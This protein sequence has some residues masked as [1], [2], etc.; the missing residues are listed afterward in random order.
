MFD[1]YTFGFLESGWAV[2]KVGG[3]EVSGTRFRYRG[4][5]WGERREF[6]VVYDL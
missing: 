3:E 2:V 1:L 6:F 5:L 4:L